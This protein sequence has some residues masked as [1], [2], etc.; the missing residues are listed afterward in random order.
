VLPFRTTPYRV[1][2]DL[3]VGEFGTLTVSPGVQ[4]NPDPGAGITVYGTLNMR[5]TANQPIRVF[6]ELPPNQANTFLGCYS[7][8]AETSVK[9]DDS[10]LTIQWCLSTCSH[11]GFPFAMLWRGFSC[12]CSYT[13]GRFPTATECTTS[14]YGNSTQ[15]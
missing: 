15:V 9:I 2:S 10:S 7:S 3:R 4:L 14:C 12:G 5:G 13:L 6:R 1:S 11:R 8:A